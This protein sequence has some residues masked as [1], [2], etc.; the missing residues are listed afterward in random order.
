MQHSEAL[1]SKNAQIIKAVK[2]CQV[3]HDVFTAT[4]YYH[5]LLLLF[6]KPAKCGTGIIGPLIYGWV[7]YISGSRT[8]PILRST[9]HSEFYKVYVLGH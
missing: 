2:E 4:L 7:V 3:S 9:L 5:S 8:V 1:D 6:T